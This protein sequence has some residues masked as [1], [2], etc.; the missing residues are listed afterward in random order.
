MADEGDECTAIASLPDKRLRP[1]Q[2]MLQNVVATANF[3]GR[4][5][6][7]KLAWSEQGEFNPDAFAAVS[8]RLATPRTTALVFASGK[9]VC[10]GAKTVSSAKLALMQYYRKVKRVCAEAIISNVCVQ[11]MV[12][13]GQLAPSL[14]IAAI[15]RQH[16]L[17]SLYS[18]ELF[19]GLRLKIYTDQNKSM[20]TL[21]FKQGTAVIIGAKTMED[22]EKAWCVLTRTVKE[23]ESDTAGTSRADM[24]VV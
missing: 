23:A 11:N 13:S 22:I 20:K 19:P 17:T 12:A 10:I 7:V 5:D 18:P 16:Q 2:V 3:L 9:V 8:L 14:N 1:G 6:L 24:S 4:I 15:A 21:I